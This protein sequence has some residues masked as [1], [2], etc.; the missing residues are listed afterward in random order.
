V[1]INACSDDKAA[2]NAEA[3]AGKNA[4]SAFVSCL[5]A[6][7][8]DA[9]QVAVCTGKVDKTKLT[10]LAYLFNGSTPPAS[11]D[12]DAM[13]E[14]EKAFFEELEKSKDV[15]TSAGITLPVV[16]GE[17]PDDRPEYA[18]PD[19]TSQDEL[20]ALIDNA[21]DSLRGAKLVVSTTIS[22][23]EGGIKY[24][25]KR[26]EQIDSAAQKYSYTHKINSA[27]VEVRYYSDNVYYQYEVGGKFFDGEKTY[28]KKSPYNSVNLLSTSQHAVMMEY[29][30]DWETC[31]ISA[32]SGKIKVVAYGSKNGNEE[33][34]ITFTADKKYKSVKYTLKN[35]AKDIVE[36]RKYT[37]D[38]NPALPSGFSTEQFTATCDN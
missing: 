35:S 14:Y 15:L 20:K 6:A 13:S 17:E 37:Y 26:V 10:Y 36:M 28:C 8:G 11:V 7:G 23:T 12:R 24:S 22:G 33:Y 5:T 18:V 38:A 19:G 27:M 2:T 1:S 21:N 32:S 3:E 34:E 30:N 25:A 31:T 16:E 9:A 4:A 29:R